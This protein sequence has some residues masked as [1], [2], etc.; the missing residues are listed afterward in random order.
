MESVPNSIAFFCSLY[1][2]IGCKKGGGHSI[3]KDD[4][5]LRQ[6]MIVMMEYYILFSLQ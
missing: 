1:D 6:E 3:V 2:S 5:F 4:V